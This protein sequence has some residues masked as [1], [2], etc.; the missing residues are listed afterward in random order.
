MKLFITLLA[1]TLPFTGLLAQS[2]TTEEAKRV[3]LG[4]RRDSRNDDSKDVV[5]GRDGRPVYE[6]RGSTNERNRQARINQV[7]REYDAKVRSIRNN[8]TLS[9]S[10]KER[11][12]RDL[13]EERSRR[14]R[15]I[16]SDRNR[17]DNDHRNDD[18]R[19]DDRRNDDRR[20][21]DRSYERGY[22]NK[23]GKKDKNKGNNGKHKG[24]QKG[25]GN[26]HRDRD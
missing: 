6:E 13:E 11:I 14:I 17:R 22:E 7:N 5:L 8:N 1:A 24:W 3:I 16:N 4:E 23:K 12:I 25:K 21:D 10:E 26:P 9:R 19:N 2:Q 15:E 20:R 18:R